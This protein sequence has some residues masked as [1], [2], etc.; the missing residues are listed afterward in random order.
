[1]ATEAKHWYQRK[2]HLDEDNP[3]TNIQVAAQSAHTAIHKKKRGDF[4]YSD[5]VLDLY[6]F[7]Q[8]LV[9]VFTKEIKTKHLIKLMKRRIWENEWCPIIIS[10]S[11]PP[12]GESRNANLA[13]V[14]YLTQL[15]TCAC[16]L[17]MP[18]C[19]ASKIPLKCNKQN[20]VSRTDLLQNS[21]T[22]QT[23]CGLRLKC[24]S[25]S[26]QSGSVKDLLCGFC[27]VY[28]F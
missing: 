7:T 26:H 24:C 15:Q 21:C 23:L 13:L 5:V 6:T 19:S 4:W 16:A 17:L 14:Q 12:R 8:H 10:C 25:S 3:E 9:Q 20:N 18:T 1:M 11:Q 28:Y 22:R 27:F 2:I